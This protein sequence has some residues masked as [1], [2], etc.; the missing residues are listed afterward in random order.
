MFEN[1]YELNKTII[2]EYVYKILCK[3]IIFIGYLI[4]VLGLLIGL[5]IKVNNLKIAVLGISFIAL[6]SAIFIPFKAIRDIE[7]NTKNLHQGNFELTIIKF[8]D[9]ITFDEG[10]THLEFQYHDLQS[11]IET[12]N[13]IAIKLSFFSYIVLNKQGFVVGDLSDFLIFIN[14]K[15]RLNSK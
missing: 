5:L 10:D 11:L 2:K 6:F 4:F 14:M 8:D 9:V 15:L 1:Q 7:T 13:L 3:K 12:D